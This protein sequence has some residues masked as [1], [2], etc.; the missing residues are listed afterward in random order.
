M[1]WEVVT[2]ADYFTM[3]NDDKDIENNNKVETNV[4]N[5]DDKSLLNKEKETKQLLNKNYNTKTK[6][7]LIV[8]Y[9]LKE[10]FTIIK[11]NHKTKKILLTFS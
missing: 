9:F 4:N 11:I 1:N 7:N 5:N 8:K 6:L 2:I 10:P 3:I